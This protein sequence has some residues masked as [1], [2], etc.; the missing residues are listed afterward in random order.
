MDFAGKRFFIIGDSHTVSTDNN[1]RPG[2]GFREKLLEAGAAKAVING[3]IGRSAYSFVDTG[4]IETILK[5]ALGEGY[6]VVVLWL[7]TNDADGHGMD[8][9]RTAFK[10]L[11]DVCMAANVDVFQVGP[12]AF[13]NSVK[14]AIDHVTP[15]NQRA[16]E[17]VQIGKNIF[18][19]H[20]IDSRQGTAGVLTVAQGREA[21]GMHFKA[22]AAPIWTDDIFAQFSAFNGSSLPNF[23]IGLATGL[24]PR[25]LGYS[26]SPTEQAG[27]C[28]PAFDS[29]TGYV[30]PKTTYPS[31]A[32]QNTGIRAALGFFVMTAAIIGA[33]WVALKK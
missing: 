4:G 13:L 9:N 8:A 31:S 2:Q 21:D 26:N 1:G 3:K 17:V 32:K 23:T 29:D 6:D 18:G 27:C 11:Y 7:G 20:F 16:A 33:V 5:P 19:D 22:V 25:M 14:A 15:I 10:K 12:P 30:P 28:E 24:C